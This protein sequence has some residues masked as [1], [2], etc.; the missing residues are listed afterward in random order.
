MAFSLR[1]HRISIAAGALSLALIAPVT[2]V[3]PGVSHHVLPVANA[4]TT[5]DT[6]TDRYT[7]DNF[8]G[9]NEAVV[10]GITL[11]AGDKIEPTTKT[12]FN[13]TFRNDNGTLY[14]VRPHSAAAFKTGEVDIP[15]KVTP[16]GEK[17]FNTTLKLNVVD[18]GDDSWVPELP[19]FNARQAV[20]FTA[21]SSQNVDALSVPTDAAVAKDGLA[22]LSWGVKNE[23]GVIRVTAPGTWAGENPEDIDIPV[24]ISKGGVTEKRTV[25]L[26][27]TPPKTAKAANDAGAALGILG[28]LLGPVLGSLIGGATGGGTGGGGGLKLGPLVEIHDNPVHVEIKDN[29]RDNAANA[30]ATAEVKDN[31]RDNVRDNAANATATV[32]VKD[33]IR[34]NVRDNSATATAD[35]HDNVKDNVKENVKENVKDNVKDNVR[36]NTASAEVSAPVSVPVNVPVDVNGTVDVLPNG[37]G[38]SSKSGNDGA[39][40]NGGATG[41]NGSS[42][43]SSTSQPNSGGFEDPRC[44]A[45]LVG[46]GLPLVALVPV[47][48]ANV[49]RIPGFEGIQDA[50]KA[51]AASGP[52]LNISEEQLAAGVGGFAGALALAAIVGAATTCVPVKADPAPENTPADEESEENTPAAN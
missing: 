41:S 32:E 22:P 46:I 2:T 48:L 49:F 34:D 35:V 13:W 7:T 14:V 39:A 6:F 11:E 36:D 20:D 1:S 43:S 45:S 51:A 10:Q 52:S 8:W 42:G 24:T 25:R 29:V 31:I 15:V 50:L 33:N 26:T 18:K 28:N 44:I 9:K 19:D 40:A 47:L 3:V 37:L 21:N 17:T 30:T 4:A 16:A 23:N 27:A 12:I 5:A 38:G